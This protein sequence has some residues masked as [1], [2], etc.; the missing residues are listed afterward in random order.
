MKDGNSPAQADDQAGTK[1]DVARVGHVSRRSCKQQ[2]VQENAHKH[3]KGS[4]HT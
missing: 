1:H 3:E 4:R 2:S